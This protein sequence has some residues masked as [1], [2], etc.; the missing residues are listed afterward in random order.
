MT[1]NP[2]R[3]VGQHLVAKTTAENDYS[4]IIDGLVAGRFMLW[5]AALG[6]SLWFW[7][8]TTPAIAQ[9]ELA[10]SG[11]AETLEE[12][13]LQFRETLDKWLAWAMAYDGPVYW[14][15]RE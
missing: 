7:T 3:F 13:R 10:S 14:K 15:G 6:A 5:P 9:V 12:A 11:E 4:V 1:L 2:Q 8:I